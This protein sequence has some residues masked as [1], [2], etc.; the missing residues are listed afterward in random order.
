MK[1]I[2]LSV[3][4]IFL[5]FAGLFIGVGVV[6]AIDAPDTDQAQCY[7]EVESG[8]NLVT[9]NGQFIDDFFAGDPPACT[10]GSC[11]QDNRCYFIGLG[12]TDEGGKRGPKCTEWRN[13][14]T[15]TRGTVEDPGT[16]LPDPSGSATTTGR[17][18]CTGDACVNDNPITKFLFVVINL[19]SGAIGIIIVAVIIL[20]G[21][22]Y[23]TSGGNPQQ[24]AQAKKRIINAIIALVAFFFLFAIL[25]WLIPGGIFKS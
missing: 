19:L 14:A 11:M 8:I 16:S 1:N 15:D 7:R 6:N 25:Q 20:A 23:T 13:N 17:F 3:T 22:Q 2:L 9:C 4:A 18:E 10:R 21:I 24:A 12:G 5:I